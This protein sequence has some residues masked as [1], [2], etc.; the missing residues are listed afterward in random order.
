MFKTKE[1]KQQLGWEVTA[2]QTYDPNMTPEDSIPL[3]SGVRSVGRQ[4]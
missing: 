3:N 1:I 4:L 2:Q